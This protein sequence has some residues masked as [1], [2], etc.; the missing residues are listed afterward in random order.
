[1]LPHAGDF[2]IVI[3]HIIESLDKLAFHMATS[4]T[5]RSYRDGVE[6][7]AESGTYVNERPK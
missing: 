5:A 3:V 6:S 4:Q 7:L 2:R 1:M